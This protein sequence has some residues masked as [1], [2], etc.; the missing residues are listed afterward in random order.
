M[1]GKNF[2]T[3]LGYMKESIRLL[4]WGVAAYTQEEVEASSS[5]EEVVG[6]SLGSKMGYKMVHRP[7]HM[8]MDR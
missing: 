6:S 2:Y 7:V 4:A 1:L 8:A 5:L 3:I